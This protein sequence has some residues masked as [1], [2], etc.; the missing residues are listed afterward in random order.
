M[1]ADATFGHCEHPATVRVEHNSIGLWEI[2]LPGGAERVTCETFEDAQRIAYLSAAH[3][4][5]CELIVHDAYHRVVQRQ[6]ISGAA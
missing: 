4:G 5:P 1:S 6:L 3:A 2:E